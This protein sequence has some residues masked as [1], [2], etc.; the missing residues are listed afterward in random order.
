MEPPFPHLPSDV[1]E[2][3]LAEL[4]PRLKKK[5]A[6]G[7]R[8][9]SRK[10]LE[11]PSLPANWRHGQGVASSGPGPQLC[12]PS[13][14]HHICMRGFPAA[15][16]CVVLRSQL[17]AQQMNS[18]LRRAAMPVGKTDTDQTNRCIINKWGY[19]NRKG[20]NALNA[21]GRALESDR[22]KF[23]PQ[24][25]LGWPYNSWESDSISP[26]LFYVQCDPLIIHPPIEHKFTESCFE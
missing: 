7:R 10:P 2:T 1:D 26:T 24:T 11:L 13:R 5:Y 22:P 25:Y 15:G 3:C 17:C 4:L 23:K 21:R 9:E 18:A 16:H 8:Q 14:T 20:G 12:L 6:C 19:T